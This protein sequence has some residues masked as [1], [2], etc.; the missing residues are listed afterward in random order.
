MLPKDTLSSYLPLLL[1]LLAYGKL[2]ATIFELMRMISA[3]KI[4]AA[5]SELH[6]RIFQLSLHRNVSSLSAISIPSCV[7]IKS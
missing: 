6:L 7:M 2:L 3:H 4:F 5:I 1:P